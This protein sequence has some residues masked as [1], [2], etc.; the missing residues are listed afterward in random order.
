LCGGRR[1]GGR[2][3]REGGGEGRVL[4]EGEQLWCGS[5]VERGLA[6]RWEGGREGGREG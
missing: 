2:E 6:L 3:G 1:R 5:E 4:K